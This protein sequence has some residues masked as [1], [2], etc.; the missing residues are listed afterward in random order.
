MAIGDGSGFNWGNAL[1]AGV[2]IAMSFSSS[3][4]SGVPHAIAE[5]QIPYST[6]PKLQNPVG[7]AA[8]VYAC[9]D[10]SC[11]TITQLVIW[12]ANYLRDIPTTWGELTTS[13]TSVA[14]F[15]EIRL[16]VIPFLA[17]ATDGSQWCIHLGRL[18]WF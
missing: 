11:D 4:N 12:P 17:I 14:G 10:N 15:S 8:A 1:P 16:A 3:P 5:F 18:E 13:P 2:Q 6:F 9:S 7:F